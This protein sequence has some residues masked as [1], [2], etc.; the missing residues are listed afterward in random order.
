MFKISSLEAKP[1]VI[2][3]GVSFVDL[4]LIL[5]FAYLGQAQ[6]PY[7]RLDDFL[8]AGE[9]LQIRGIKEGRIHFMTNHVHTVQVQQ[10]ASNRSFDATISSTQETVNEPAVKRPREDDD[11][12]IQEASEIMKMLLEDNDQDND[13]IQ[14]KTTTAGPLPI[15][16]PIMQLNRGQ[17][18]TR[19]SITRGAVAGQPSKALVV[20]IP[21]PN[22]NEKPKAPCRFCSSMFS[23]PRVAKHEKECTQNPNRATA[24]CDI[25]KVQLKPSTLTAHK[26]SKHGISRKTMNKKSEY[27]ETKT[28]INTRHSLIVKSSQE[29]PV[30]NGFEQKAVMTNVAHAQQKLPLMNGSK[31]STPM[32]NDTQQNTVINSDSQP[33]QTTSETEQ[34]SGVNSGSQEAQTSNG[35]TKTLIVSSGSEQLTRGY[36]GPH[37]TQTSNIEASVLSPAGPMIHLGSPGHFVPPVPIRQIKIEDKD[38]LEAPKAQ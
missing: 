6:V 34:N 24:F 27:D 20:A 18:S 2:I 11:M 23:E 31:Q 17:P 8:K 12:L 38:E 30:M 19:F 15:Q 35:F 22:S 3:A 10:A 25:C 5:D 13:N 14:V 7:E 16:Q 29:L 32:T 21:Q 4:C 26:N 36:T 33:A 1:I 28:K 37:Y 9:L